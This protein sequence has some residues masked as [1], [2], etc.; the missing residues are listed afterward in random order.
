MQVAVVDDLEEHVGGIGS[1][2]EIADS[3][4]TRTL[5]CV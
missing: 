5:G 3:S 4:M 2:A 1:V